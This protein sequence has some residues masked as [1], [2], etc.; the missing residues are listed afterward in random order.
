MT[1]RRRRRAAAPTR[2]RSRPARAGNAAS[3]RFS[4]AAAARPARPARRSASPR[5]RRRAAG[6]ATTDRT[7][8]TRPDASRRSASI[9]RRSAV[10]GSRR[11]I[12]HTIDI[13]TIAAHANASAADGDQRLAA[14]AVAADSATTSNAAPPRQSTHGSVAANPARAAFARDT[15][16]ARIGLHR[17]RH[18]RGKRRR[19]IDDVVRPLELR[20]G[21]QCP[22][23]FR[24]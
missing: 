19:Q 24:V 2:R 4:A 21:G 12:L 15:Q 9:W 8:T 10:T 1:S 7:T 13:A 17:L 22:P 20:R 5:P 6:G 11:C 14:I 16:P 18:E 23:S 3:G